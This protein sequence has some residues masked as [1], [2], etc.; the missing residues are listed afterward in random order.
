VLKV[1]LQNSLI[2][3]GDDR[4]ALNGTAQDDLISGR[5]G[6]DDLAGGAGNDVID[7]GEGNDLLAGGAGDDL[8]NGGPG[9]DRLF[10]GAGADLFRMG[11]VSERTDTINDFNA[12]EGDKLLLADLLQGTGYDPAQAGKWLQFQAADLDGSGGQNDVRVRVDL[13]GEGGAYQSTVIFNMLNP[14]GIVEQIEGGTL[15]IDKI[16]VARRID[17]SG[18]GA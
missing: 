14:V 9:Q 12:D 6:N 13:D 1:Q 11:S 10:G 17:P 7:G 18:A 5:A 3:G 16:V 15:D 8:L 4:D 2:R